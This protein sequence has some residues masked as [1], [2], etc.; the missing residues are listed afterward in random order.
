MLPRR[1]LK[2][3]LNN[4]IKPLVELYVKAGRSKNATLT[5]VAECAIMEAMVA[6]TAIAKMNFAEALV[7]EAFVAEALV[8]ESQ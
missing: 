4:K 7:A 3:F 8:S 6:E 1:S 5:S 2:V